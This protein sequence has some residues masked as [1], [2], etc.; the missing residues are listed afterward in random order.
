MLS[1]VSSICSI[2]IKVAN[3][4]ASAM[5]EDTNREIIAASHG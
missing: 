2:G 4:K 3:S 5:E 1:K